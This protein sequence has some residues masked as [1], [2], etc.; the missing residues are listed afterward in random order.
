M[1]HYGFTSDSVVAVGYSNG[2]NIAASMLLLRPE[3]MP[4]AILFRAM[5]P[6]V[7]NKLPELSSVHVWIGAGDQDP[8]IPPSEAQGL[9]ELLRRAGADV[10]IRFFNAGHGLTNDDLEAARHWLGA[11]NKSTREK[12]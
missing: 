10:T 9:V 1:Q 6:L 3:V 4:A 7:P 2:A 8:I 12:L 5:V 11:L